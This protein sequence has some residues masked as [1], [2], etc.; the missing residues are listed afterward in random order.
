MIMVT[1]SGQEIA[2]PTGAMV[3]VRDVIATG[4]GWPRGGGLPAGAHM[5]A[6]INQDNE[7]ITVSPFSNV[8][9]PQ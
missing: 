8:P 9:L 6:A 7:S 2:R 1:T 4:V 5:S 3:G